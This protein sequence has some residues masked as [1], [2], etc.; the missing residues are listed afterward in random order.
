MKRYFSKLN[1]SCYPLRHYKALMIEEN[2]DTLELTEA[3]ID[4]SSGYYFCVEYLEI[5]EVG[6]GCGKSCKDYKPRNEKNGRCRHHR[7]TY[8]ETD[9]KI[10]ITRKG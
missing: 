7:H 5:G 10:T 3:K 9:K 2:C 8:Y 6:E 4:P 1:E